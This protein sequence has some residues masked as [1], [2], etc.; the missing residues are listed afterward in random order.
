MSTATEVQT[1]TTES[2]KG[3]FGRDSLYMLLWAVQ[4]AIAALC[5]PIITRMLGVSQFG[6]VVSTFAVMQIVVA[7]ACFSLQ[8]A[9]QRVFANGDTDRDARRVVTLAVILALG[10][11]A[12]VDRTGSLWSPAIG[13]GHY[14][15]ALVYGVAWAALWAITNAALGLI[16]SQDKLVAFGVITL[17]QSV[18]AE[19]LGISLVSLGHHTASEYVLGHLIAQGA[20]AV[21]ALIVARPMLVRRRDLPMLA[22][23]LAF[24]IGLVPGALTA[25]VLDTSDRLIIRTDL[26]PGAVARYAV[27]YNVANLTM[28]LLYLLNTTWMPRVFALIDTRVRTAVLAESR[29]FLYALLVPVIVGLCAISPII[30]SI[31]VPAAYRPAGLLLIVAVVAVTAFPFAGMMAATRVLLFSG[32]TLAVGVSTVVA[33]LANIGLNVLLVPELGIAGASFATMCS[34][35]LLFALLAIRARLIVRL[36]R[37]RARLISRIL[38]AGAISLASTQL[39]SSPAITAGRTLV[40]IG[41]ALA[42]AAM[43]TNILAPTRHSLAARIAAIFH[44]PN[45]VP[46]N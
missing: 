37:P 3:L 9:V 44:S 17:L 5:T 28:V 30:L 31:W 24:A 20:A 22:R 4:L 35:S 12:L 29:D 36:P 21:V 39:P 43:L 13:L 15:P 38:A 19:I 7:L 11:W 40:A 1:D 18:V 27:A 23:A 42:V 16:R 25:F 34:Y 32:N 26:G 2:M 8:S 14:G 33:G 10:V 41:C 46:A 45:L 6:L